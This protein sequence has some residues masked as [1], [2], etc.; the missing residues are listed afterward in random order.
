[1]ALEIAITPNDFESNHG[2]G[3]HPD[4]TFEIFCNGTDTYRVTHATILGHASS[5]GIPPNAIAALYRYG[6]P[7]KYYISLD[8]PDADNIIEKLHGKQ[9]QLQSMKVTCTWRD[10]KRTFITGTL[11]WLPVGIKV[12]ALINALQPI[13]AA[14]SVSIGPAR[15]NEKDT[16]PFKLVLKENSEVPHYLILTMGEYRHKV[17]VA[18]PGR[19]FAC[20]TCYEEGHTM[21][22]CPKR[23]GKQGPPKNGP[24]PTIPTPTS[25]Q[26]SESWTTVVKKNMQPK[27]SKQASQ[28]AKK[29]TKPV[30]PAYLNQAGKELKLTPAKKS[31]KPPPVMNLSSELSSEDSR[32][33][34]AHIKENIYLLLN[35]KKN[36]K[37]SPEK[38]PLAGKKAYTPIRGDNLDSVWDGNKRKISAERS[39]SD[40]K[41]VAVADEESSSEERPPTPF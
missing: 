30:K 15:T 20:P 2:L 23:R 5:L 32:S 34:G 1:M 28:E 18:L 35:Q 12:E 3:S 38:T 36:K 27:T 37:R 21:F 4:K 9:Y 33:P 29:P 40:K 8:G 17:R 26:S 13:S 41:R 10:V 25:N 11:R 39:D 24:E 19:A 7:R 6:D 31:K 14:D 16:R 22:L